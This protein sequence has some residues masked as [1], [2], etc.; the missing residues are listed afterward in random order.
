MRRRY[1]SATAF[2]IACP[3]CLSICSRQHHRRFHHGPHVFVAPRRGARELRQRQVTAPLEALV[4]DLLWRR[5]PC[6]VTIRPAVSNFSPL[7]SV[8]ERSANPRPGQSG[9]LPLSPGDGVASS[10]LLWSGTL[11]VSVR[12]SYCPANSVTGLGVRGRCGGSSFLEMPTGLASLDLTPVRSTVST[13]AGSRVAQC[14]AARRIGDV[15]HHRI[16]LGHCRCVDKIQENLPQS[17]LRAGPGRA[18]THLECLPSAFLR[19][20]PQL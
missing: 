20:P 9:V 4:L 14:P 18:A 15:Q 1:S 16:V 5:W 3:Y 17:P 7:S 6:A 13:L 8:F 10:G 2:A 19:H 11:L 12:E